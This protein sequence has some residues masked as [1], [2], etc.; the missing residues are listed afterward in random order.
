MLTLVWFRRD[1]RLADN[2]ALVAAARDG[3]VCPIYIHDPEAK[4]RQGGAGRWWLHHA[5]AALDASLGRHGLAL[6]IR[7]GPALETLR[8]VIHETGA[9][10]VRWNRLYDPPLIRRDRHVKQALRDAGV[11]VH[12]H[13]ADLLHEPWTV[14]TG[15]GSDY[16]VFTPFWRALRRLGEPEAPLAVPDLQGPLARPWSEPLGALGLLPRIPW[17][18]GLREA[19][20]PG[21]E[22]A[23]RLDRFVTDALP[24]YH[25]DRDYPAIPGTSRL[26]PHLHF[27]EVSPRQVWAATTEADPEG[28]GTAAFR[29]EI[30]WREFAHHV[31][32]HHPELPDEP[33]DRRFRGFP[34]RADPAG[35]LLTAWRS[36]C[37]GFPIVDAG[38]RELR[39]TGWMH[40]RVR[41]VAG[42]LLVKNLRLPWQLGERWFRDNLV[43][44]DP[45]SNALGWQWVAGCGA[46]A[47]PYFRIFNPIRQGERFDPDGDYVARWVPEL[48]ALPPRQRHAPWEAAA[49]VLARAGVRLDRDYPSPVV[50]LRESRQAALD[51]FARIKGD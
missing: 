28:P 45:A 3:A 30:G 40:N 24:R 2:P 32:F 47:A 8:G 49:N 18:T 51:A 50:D 6:I 11:D 27:G 21:E 48:A 20:T 14:R 10:G 41:M 44:A 42:S 31:L 35:E 13:K 39:T 19:W 36:G 16:R 33:L 9:E 22:A 37:T 25:T 23:R 7:R 26:S 1:L 34:W 46:D 38:M 12:S 5:L 43:D 15:Q 29:T 17:D 4:D